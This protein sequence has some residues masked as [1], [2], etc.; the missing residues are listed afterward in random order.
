MVD[1]QTEIAEELQRIKSDTL[2]NR[3]NKNFRSAMEL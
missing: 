2:F 1:I 3:P